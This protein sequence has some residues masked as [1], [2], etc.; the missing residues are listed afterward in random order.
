[1]AC[2]SAIPHLSAMR[3]VVKLAQRALPP[4]LSSL[5]NVPDGLHYFQIL[6]F[7][8]WTQNVYYFSV[9]NSFLFVDTN[10]NGEIAPRGR[11]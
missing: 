6:H 4:P 2:W 10:D 5:Q 7:L 8:P 3:I 9:G 11:Q 1:M